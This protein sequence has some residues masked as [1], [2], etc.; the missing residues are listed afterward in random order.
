ML[1][2][3]GKR[4]I[5]SEQSSIYQSK[6]SHGLYKLRLVQC[7]E[8]NDVMLYKKQYELLVSSSENFGVLWMSASFCALPGVKII[9]NGQGSK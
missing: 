3:F 7:A 4:R 1:E 6:D 9:I 2:Q 8:E 5:I